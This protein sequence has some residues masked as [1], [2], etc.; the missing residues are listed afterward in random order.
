MPAAHT[1]GGPE[2]VGVLARG[3]HFFVAAGAGWGG[4]GAGQEDARDGAVCGCG[5]SEEGGVEGDGGHVI[6]G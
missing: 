4:V 1:A 5:V 3:C 2:D 6:G